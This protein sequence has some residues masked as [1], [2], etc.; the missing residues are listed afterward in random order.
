[1][2]M[3]PQDLVEDIAKRK[4]V[5]YLGSGVSAN[6]QNDDGKRPATW[7]TFLNDILR[8][9]K[10]KL[11]GTEDTI[12]MLLDKDDYLMACE[13]IVSKL[14]ERDF[15]E[16][17]AD[18][19]RRPGYHPGDLHRIIFSL[20]SKIVI[21][22]NIDKIYD[23]YATSNSNGT[24]IIKSYRDNIARYLRSPDYLII[25]A[26]GTI[27]DTDHIVFTH[28]QYSRVRNEYSGFYRILDAL[29]LTHTFI[30]LGCGI[31]DP[32]IQLVLENYNFLFPGCRPHYMVTANNSIAIDVMNC[33]SQNRNLEFLT[34][35]NADGTHSQL[36]EN[37]KVLDSLVTNKRQKIAATASW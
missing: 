30:F 12:H 26:H 22:P 35:E 28:G 14:G 17:T 20:D 24:V 33:L 11:G 10:E 32:D 27:D 13:L 36:L 21:T 19:F 15:G 3:W 7:K 23:Q 16:L 6:C 31:S 1:M 9:R 37:L 25:K 18:E 2:I 4:S 29:M 8:E 34:Y 5:L